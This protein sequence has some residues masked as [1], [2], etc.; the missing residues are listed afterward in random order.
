MYAVIKT[1]GK[2]Y[3]VA[4]DDIIKIEKLDAE[5]GEKVEFEDVLMVGSEGNTSIGTPLLE[6]AIVTAEV[7]EQTRAAKIIV[8]KKKRRHNY[9]RKKGHR[10]HQTVVRI[11]GISK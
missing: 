6:G 11:T 9:R 7:L 1:G 3:R 10:Q 4:K 2:Q 5:A 8:F